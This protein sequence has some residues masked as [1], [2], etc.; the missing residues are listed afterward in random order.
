[1]RTRRC[2]RVAGRDWVC[3]AAHGS[4]CDQLTAASR[5]VELV[6]HGGG[7]RAFLSEYLAETA[8]CCYCVTAG[9]HNSQV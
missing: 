6:S 8:W 1:M 5:N 4:G 7:L 3:G 9:R 2:G